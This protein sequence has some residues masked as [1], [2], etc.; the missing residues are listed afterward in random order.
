MTN[1]LAATGLGP[2]IARRV[3]GVS[4]GALSLEKLAVGGL[5]T[6]LVALILLNVVTR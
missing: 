4:E 3:V 5:M 1:Q 2:R 6:L